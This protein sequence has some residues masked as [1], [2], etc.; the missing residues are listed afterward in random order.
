MDEVE[1]Q[2]AVS[3][4]QLRFHQVGD[5]ERA[6]EVVLLLV[7]EL[8]VVGVAQA[9]IRSLAGACMRGRGEGT[10]A[11]VR[12]RGAPAGGCERAKARSS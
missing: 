2:H 12:G 8:R 1:V 11:A 6:E 5:V 4:R 10:G 3:G 7:Q 9:L